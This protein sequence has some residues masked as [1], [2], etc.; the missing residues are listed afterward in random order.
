M[1]A[2][3][4]N[5][6]SGRGICD[7]CQQRCLCYQGHGSAVDRLYALRAGQN[8]GSFRGDCSDYACPHASAVYTLLGTTRTTAAYIEKNRQL[9]K[10]SNINNNELD[11]LELTERVGFFSKNESRAGFHEHA[12]CSANGVCDRTTGTCK[13]RKGKEYIAPRISSNEQA[14][15]LITGYSGPSCDRQDCPMQCSGR[16]RCMDM[17][18]LALTKE[19]LPLSNAVDRL[20]YDGRR[21]G[22]TIDGYEDSNTTIGGN[23]FFDGAWDARVGRMCVCDSSWPVGLGAGE[24]QQVWCSINVVI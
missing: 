21:T 22:K 19:A 5:G 15:Y 8:A 12:E 11:V 18:R 10:D 13:C 4:P 1:G 24:T 3:C 2:G 23:G 6:C 14:I 9:I 16:G 7:H 20:R 17:H